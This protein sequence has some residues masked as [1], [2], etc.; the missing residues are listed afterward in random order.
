MRDV[1]YQVADLIV[2]VVNELTASDQMFILQIS[3]AL[4]EHQQLQQRSRRV[5]PEVFVVHNLKSARSE[6]QATEQWKVRKW[7]STSVK[8]I[9]ISFI[10]PTGTCDRYFPWG[11][12]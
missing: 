12:Y 6:S 3:Q 7:M 1:T 11:A 5:I 8:L 9:L 10:F 4:A 2:V